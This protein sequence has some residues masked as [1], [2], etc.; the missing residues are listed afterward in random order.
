[1]FQR[2]NCTGCHVR[3]HS[4]V[5][6]RESYSNKSFTPSHEL[7]TLQPEA[8]QPPVDL[9]LPIILDEKAN[10]LSLSPILEREEQRLNGADTVTEGALLGCKIV[11]KETLS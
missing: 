7:F 5:P 4:Q 9:F 1:M 8:H 10:K 3:C 11:P 2:S 6:T